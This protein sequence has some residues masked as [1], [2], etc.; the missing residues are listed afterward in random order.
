MDAFHKFHLTLT[1]LTFIL[2]DETAKKRKKAS[3]KACQVSEVLSQASE[4]SQTCLSNLAACHFRWGNHALVGRLAS[5]VLEKQPANVKLLYRRGVANLE[6]RDFEAVRKDLVRKCSYELVW[7][8]CILAKVDIF[9]YCRIFSFELWSL[10]LDLRFGENKIHTVH[11][12]HI[13]MYVLHQGHSG[14]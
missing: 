13:Y 12:T 1:L 9:A 10:D 3:D 11:S 2:E 6:M 7:G 5:K 8:S 14:G 4:I